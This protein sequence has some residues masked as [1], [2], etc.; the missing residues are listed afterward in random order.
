MAVEDI[1]ACGGRPMRATTRRRPTRRIAR[2]EEGK[3]REGFRKRPQMTTVWKK[4]RQ[5]GGKGK[6]TNPGRWDATHK[7][8]VGLRDDQV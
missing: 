7:P 3:L 2:R 4:R 8:D 5:C 1:V 6:Q